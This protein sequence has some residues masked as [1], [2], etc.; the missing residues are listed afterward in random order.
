MGGQPLRLAAHA[1]RAPV[2]RGAGLRA[3]CPAGAALWPGVLCA[4]VGCVAVPVAVR[5]PA[6]VRERRADVAVRGAQGRRL[7]PH[8]G[9]KRGGLGDGRPT[10][11]RP[12]GEAGRSSC[13]GWRVEHPARSCT[14]GAHTHTSPCPSS[15][16]AGALHLDGLPRAPCVRS[17]C[18]HDHHAAPG[19]ARV[20]QASSALP[21]PLLPLA[22]LEFNRRVV[23]CRCRCCPWRCS[24]ST[25]E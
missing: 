13:R 17:V 4:A 25:G 10:C 5:V 23:R 15:S 20:Q 6:A 19:A 16:C 3:G 8:H 9:E 21:L 7:Q 14:S 24:S 2:A 1:A 18:Y 22:L 11:G 12:G